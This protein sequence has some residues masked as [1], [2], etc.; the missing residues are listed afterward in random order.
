MN[1][2]YKVWTALLQAFCSGQWI[3]LRFE[4]ISSAY[5]WKCYLH[6]TEVLVPF[7]WSTT[8]VWRGSSA[9]SDGWHMFAFSHGM[10]FQVCMAGQ[11]WM[12]L[13][14]DLPWLLLS[15]VGGIF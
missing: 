1:A 2:F 5:T 8:K 14:I 9:N 10:L 12:R 3:W 7:N 15:G 11:Q 4:H 6:H 13:L